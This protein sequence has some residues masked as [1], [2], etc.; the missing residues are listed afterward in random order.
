[1]ATLQGEDMYI[2]ILF[3]VK[4]KFLADCHPASP[5]KP[6]TTSLHPT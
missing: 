4:K 3:C 1:M 2:N 6:T 5:P